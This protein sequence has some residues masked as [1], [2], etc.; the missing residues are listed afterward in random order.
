MNDTSAHIATLDQ[1]DEEILTSTVSDDA[2]E[3]AAG[4]ERVVDTMAVCRAATAFFCF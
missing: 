1:A 4:V 3:A 2:L